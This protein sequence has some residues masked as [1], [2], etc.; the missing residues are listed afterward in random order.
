MALLTPYLASLPSLHQVDLEEESIKK[1]A[2][3]LTLC[4]KI[5]L[6]SLRVF[7]CF[8]AFGLII[9]AF[10]GIFL[11]TNFSQVKYVTVEW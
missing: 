8:V 6:Y 5:V 1:R 7:M 9:A 4:Q 3:S 11:A 2:A 10:Y